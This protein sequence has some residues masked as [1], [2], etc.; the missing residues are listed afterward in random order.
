MEA[1]VRA[2]I[3][4]MQAEEEEEERKKNE[5][6]KAP[7]VVA[8]PSPVEIVK[9]SPVPAGKPLNVPKIGGSSDEDSDLD[10]LIGD[11]DN[12]FVK[13]E[14]VN[15]SVEV[16]Q[17]RLHTPSQ[18]PV[19][20]PVENPPI[21]NIQTSGPSFPAQGN[22][23]PPRPQTGDPLRT[24]GGM[25]DPGQRMPQGLPPTNFNIP[26]MATT[27]P[28][29]GA[30][31]LVAPGSAGPMIR[32]VDRLGTAPAAGLDS[33]GTLPI[34][35]SRRGRPQTATSTTSDPQR[36]TSAGPSVDTSANESFNLLRQPKSVDPPQNR[37]SDEI[38]EIKSGQIHNRQEFEQEPLTQQTRTPISQ[39]VTQASPIVVN[40]QQSTPQQI[41]QPN[42]FSMQGL[43]G[44]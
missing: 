20:D 37:K 12:I 36:A 13:K 17:D 40:P 44:E 35:G 9:K 29:K 1:Q 8:N 4:R 42:N 26:R 39:P 7:A 10:D 41:Q 33:I 16:E 3:A 32:S 2:D 5:V 21:R 6:T 30:T 23:Q 19:A 22:S 27:P 11:I 24:S 38:K 18:L 14:Q 43:T 34:K 25:A 28:I 31:P 15:Q